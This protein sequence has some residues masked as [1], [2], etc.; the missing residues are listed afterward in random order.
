LHF[1]TLDN[2]YSL[3]LL[4]MRDWPNAETN[5]WQHTALTIDRHSCPRRD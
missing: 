3:G 1:I 2:T 4:W 5:M